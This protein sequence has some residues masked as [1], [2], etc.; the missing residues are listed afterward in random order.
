MTMTLP[1]LPSIPAGSVATAEQLNAIG[2][3]CNFLLA[4]PIAL[5]QDTVGGALLT[6]GGT[7]VT[8]T[9]PALIDPDGMWSAS[10]TDRLTVQTPGWYR[11][12]YMVNVNSTTGDASNAAAY[13]VT[14][15][16]NPQGSGHTSGAYW[17]SYCDFYPG[18]LQSRGVWPF[19]LYPGDYIHVIAYCATGDTGTSTYLKDP[20]GNTGFGSTLSLEHVGCNP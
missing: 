12:A 4:K 14:G 8:Y 18:A 2:A 5:V 17:A 7:T 16:N 6:T 9:T 10:N 19:Y 1:T 15:P 11:L 13:S 20:A 3:A